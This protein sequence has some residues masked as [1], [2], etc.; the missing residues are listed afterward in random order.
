LISY[1][2]YLWHLPVILWLQSHGLVFG[3]DLS[4]LVY[5]FVLVLSIT[6]A[7]AS[8][9]YF[10]VERPAMQFKKRQNSPGG[11]SASRRA[12]LPRSEA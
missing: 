5:N 11:R 1:S 8:G 7:L 3:T 4:G 9:T 6:I 12:P 2:L 10:L